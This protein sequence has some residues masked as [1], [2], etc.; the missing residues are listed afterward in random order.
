MSAS[1]GAQLEYCET[2]AATSSSFLVCAPRPGLHVARIDARY[3]SLQKNVAS[4]SDLKEWG[5]GVVPWLE[6]MQ[7]M[8]NGQVNQLWDTNA[9]YLAVRRAATPLYERPNETCDKCSGPVSVGH[10][11]WD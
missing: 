4:D 3:A 11:V 8:A 9:Q 7:E 2:G 10:R 6:P 5:L 1:V